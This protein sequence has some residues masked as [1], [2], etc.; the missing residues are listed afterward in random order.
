M[1]DPILLEIYR[2]KL[3][4]IAE[5]MGLVLQRSAFS[6][7]IKERKDLSCAVFDARGRLI[8]QAEHIPV[9]LGSMPM[10]VMSAL[11]NVSFRDGDVVILND[12]FRGGTHLPD[13]TMIEPVFVKGSLEFFVANRAHHADIGGY[14]SG[15]MPLSN[16]IFQE[17]LVIPPIKIVEGG[18]FNESALELILSN[19]RTAE[20]RKGDLQAQM[21]A[22]NVGV[23]R[24][25]ELV[26]ERGLS[27]VRAYME[28]LIN[29]SE[30]VMRATIRKVPD[31]VYEFED[32][33]ED[34]G[35]G[36]RDLRIH[37]RLEIKGDE[38]IL[39]FS[40]SCDQTKGCVNAVRAITLSAVY[41]VFIS[42]VEFSIPNNEGCF[43]PIR[44]I[45]RRGSILDAEF[46]SAVAGGNVETSQRIVDVVLGALS[47]AIPSRVP[48]ASQGSMN[49][50]AVG[51]ID[52]RSGK[53]FA[54]YETIGGGMGASKYGDGESAVHSHMTNTMN[55][56]V[57][58]LEHAY[59]F[60]VKEYSVRKD[61]GGRGLNRGGDGIVREI[62]F[63][64]EV[65]VTVISERRRIPPYGLFGGNPGKVGENY[66]VLGRKRKKMPSKFRVELKKGSGLR[67]ETPGGG[68]YA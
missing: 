33:L 36:N 43:K 64:S 2:N 41:Y 38:A 17:G 14:S 30:R 11:R 25:K 47:R 53:P 57:E 56:P 15:S 46:P 13:V 59:P 27:E 45:T 34:D 16:S 68:G 48:A 67:I 54:Y 7:N 1:P 61:S 3:S 44:V 65:E 28:E 4:S 12:P 52:P 10:S 35:A 63:L 49:N 24:L 62:E 29:Y 20:E 37:L 42:L 55:T 5:E 32:F 51:G 31:G 39:D 60:L 26:E 6:P 8:A 22:N 50:V 40:D 23:K 19:V 21:M 58:A 18:R 66:I 9:H